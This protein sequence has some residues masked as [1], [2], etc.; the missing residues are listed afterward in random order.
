[1]SRTFWLVLFAASAPAF[2]YKR[3]V[4]TGNV[5]IWWSSRGHS[6]QIDALGTPDVPAVQ[7]FTA[8]RK[9][10]QTWADVACSDLSFPDQGLSMDPRDRVVGYFPGRYNRNLVLW[11][12]RFC[13]NG[14]NGGVVPPGDGCLTEGGCANAYDCWDHGDGVIATTTTTSNRFTGQINDTDIEV[15]D[16]VGSDGSKFTFTA[17]D[18]GPCVDATQTGCV[19]IDI[20]NTITHEAGHT[21]GLDHTTDP[22]ATMY[23]T[24]PEGETSKRVLGSDDI[25]GICDIY[26]RGARTS[27]CDDDPITLTPTGSSNGGCGCSHAQTGPGATLAALAV[28]LLSRR[29]PKPAIIPSSAAA[30]ASLRVIGQRS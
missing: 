9:S 2:A 7:A 29:R 15:N 23:A 3:S 19:R 5:C 25:Q 21:L 20:Q 13:G 6:F 4:N 1:V 30:S 18:G 10:F 8:I 17:V 27:T 22:N 28:F 24:A 12:T 26:P 11:R 14:K 16:S